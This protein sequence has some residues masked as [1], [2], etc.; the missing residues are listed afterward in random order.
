[1]LPWREWSNSIPALSGIARWATLGVAI[2]SGLAFGCGVIFF[3]ADKRRDQLQKAEDIVQAERIAGIQRENLEIGTTL[4]E[5]RSIRLEL[6]RSLKPRVL[7]FL[8]NAVKSSVDGLKPFT[9]IQTIIGF[10]PD[11][12]EARRAAGNIAQI[13]VLAGWK[14]AS[15]GPDPGA[16]MEGV[17]VEQYLAP[18]PL[19]PR[20]PTAED[21]Q[22]RA[23]ERH[24]HDAAVAL[25][26]LLQANDWKA[27]LGFAAREMAGHTIPRNTVRVRVGIKPL[28]YFDPAWMKELDAK[29][30]ALRQRMDRSGRIP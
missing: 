20:L 24:S 16:A 13:L 4:E 25:V 30:K 8:G 21:Q 26:D 3:F 27:T 6:E 18:T 22:H 15:S 2:S 14:I 17:V 19:T 9:D 28:P 29:V 1:M 11:D 23:D 7:G 12:A 5:E 10:I